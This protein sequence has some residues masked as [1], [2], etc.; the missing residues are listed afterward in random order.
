MAISLIIY[1]RIYRGWMMINLKYNAFSVERT[2]HNEQTI[3][4]QLK[5]TYN[6][7]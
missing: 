1:T 3:N 5:W 7:S 2:A 4:E 6:P